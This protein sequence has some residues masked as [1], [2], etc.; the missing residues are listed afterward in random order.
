MRRPRHEVRNEGIGPYA[1]FYCEK[2]DRE[3]RS[4]PAIGQTMA[5]SAGRQ[6][7]GGLLRKV[8]IAGDALGDSIQDPK[9]VRDLTPTQLDAAWGQVEENFHECPTCK[10]IV[11]NADWDAKSGYC[12]DCTP[13]REEIAQ[14]ETEQAIGVF[15]GIASAFGLDQAAK[16]AMESA[17]Q[18][19]AQR[20]AQQAAATAAAASAAAAAVLQ[21]SAQT[22]PAGGVTCPACGKVVPAGKFCPECGAKLAPTKCPNCGTET[23]GAKFCPE[24]GTKVG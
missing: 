18:A 24:C 3:Y 7:L 19:E 4:S 2:C 1:V 12:Q 22:A 20:S 6:L 15:K 11:C 9:H 13:R 10:L 23:K 16:A 8:P 14:A 21:A 17:R 5:Q